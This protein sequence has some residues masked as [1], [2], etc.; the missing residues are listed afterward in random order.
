MR[1]DRGNEDRK[2]G[3]RMRKEGEGE[4]GDRM[5]RGLRTGESGMRT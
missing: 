5:E 3:R 4:G 2:G 1:E